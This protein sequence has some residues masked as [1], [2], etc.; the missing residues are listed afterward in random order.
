VD[1]LTSR[2]FASWLGLRKRSSEARKVGVGINLKRLK[3]DVRHNHSGRQRG[4]VP[5][6]SKFK[7]RNSKIQN[8]DSDSDSIATRVGRTNTLQP[9]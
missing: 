6:R 7:I 4:V 2:S 8:S 5:A 9:L 3:T 1:A